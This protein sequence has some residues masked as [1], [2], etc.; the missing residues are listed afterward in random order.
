[1][2]ML[3]RTLGRSVFRK[4]WWGGVRLQILAIVRNQ[5]GLLQLVCGRAGT[6]GT[7]PC[8]FVKQLHISQWI[9]A[10]MRKKINKE[11]KKKFINV[12]VSTREV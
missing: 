11:Q 4:K 9:K 8:G 10:H 3:E 7:E 1:M 5:R 6:C 2:E 12:H